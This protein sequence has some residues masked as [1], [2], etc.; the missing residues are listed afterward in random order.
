VPP[1]VT[2]NQETEQVEA[3]PIKTLRRASKRSYS[4]AKRTTTIRMNPRMLRAKLSVSML[5]MKSNSYF[6]IKKLW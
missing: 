4:F 2:L 3:Q 5:S 6:K 1:V